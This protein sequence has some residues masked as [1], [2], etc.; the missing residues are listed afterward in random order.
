MRIAT[1]VSLNPGDTFPPFHLPPSP[2]PKSQR[3]F[4]VIATL[5]H[6]GAG[7]LGSE[8]VRDVI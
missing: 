8:G 2:S 1:Y 7:R 4:I 6:N 3:F 5:I